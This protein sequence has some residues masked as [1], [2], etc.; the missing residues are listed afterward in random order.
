MFVILSIPV[1][2][3]M[4]LADV[5]LARSPMEHELMKAKGKAEHLRLMGF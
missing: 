2:V 3:L 1:L 4:T 5:F